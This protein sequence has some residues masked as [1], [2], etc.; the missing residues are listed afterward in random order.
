MG[1]SSCLKVLVRHWCRQ[2]VEL[3][4]QEG[5]YV[6][7]DVIVDRESRLFHGVFKSLVG[8]AF[9]SKYECLYQLKAKAGIT[10]AFNGF[11]CVLNV[12]YSLSTE[13]KLVPAFGTKPV[14]VL[15]RQLL[16]RW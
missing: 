5:M 7:D 4:R 13:C 1:A 3:P 9:G 16:E 10:R 15:S 8:V 11:L 6:V 14:G 12:P 2:L